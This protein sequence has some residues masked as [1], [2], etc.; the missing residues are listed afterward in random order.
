MANEILLN[1][2]R[3]KIDDCTQ[4][5][6]DQLLKSEKWGTINFETCRLEL[7]RTFTMLEEFKVLPID[8]LPDATLQQI[9]TA[10]SPIPQRIAQIRSFSIETQNP[11][12]ERDTLVSHLKN[13]ADQFFTVA[14]PYIPYLAYRKGDVQRSI[15][16]L[17][18]GV[19]NARQQVDKVKQNIE[20]KRNEI[21]D[22]VTAA[23][24]AAASV[25]VAHFTADFSSEAESQDT[26]ATRWLIATAVMAALTISASLAMILIP[27][28]ADATTPQVFQILTSKAVILGL[29]FTATIWCG[30]LYKAAKH[31]SVINKH[32]ANALKTFQAFTK[33]ASDDASR[34]AVLMETTKSIFAITPSGYLDSEASQDS[35]MKI[36]ELVKQTTQGLTPDR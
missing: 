27:I 6:I 3:A 18:Q 32:R 23:R 34:D 7:E 33:A 14:H 35:G 11:T 4:T 25:G 19:E 24:E 8:L 15:N 16:E 36:V 21:D 29:L 12:S 20:Q 31:L 13:E 22:I 1:E 2:L 28:R 17:T 10:L 5:P 30:R 9:I 26:T